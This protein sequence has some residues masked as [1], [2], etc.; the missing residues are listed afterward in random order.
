MTQRKS[1]L[2]P[3]RNFERGVCANN[4]TSGDLNSAGG[5]V[6]SPENTHTF[7]F[8][9]ATGA[10]LANVR[11]VLLDDVPW[12]YA[13][14]VCE[15]LGLKDTN[16]AL[17]GVD[18][19]DKGEHEYYSGSG[20]K[21]LLVNESGLYSL[22]FKSRKPA[23]REFKRWITSEV[24]PAIRVT[25]SYS[26][27]LPALGV[28]FSDP[29]AAARAWADEYEAKQQITG[30]AHRQAKYITHLESLFSEGLTPVQF[31]KRL[32]GVNTS[33]V[34][35]WLVVKN[36]LYDD[37]PNGHRATW[38]VLAYARDQYLTETSTTV[39]PKEKASFEAFRPVL[40]KK[41]AVWI[42]RRYL[43]G[44]L[45]MKADWNGELTHDKELA[46]L[47]NNS[48]TLST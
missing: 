10:L 38:R 28:D 11:A 32:N 21:P 37:T 35:A 7:V 30:Y 27:A 34:N 48:G 19:E 1:A 22:I 39:T 43:K 44:E 45:P 18:D 26:G 29:A 13:V 31:C 24:L 25:G 2:L 36:W 47:A 33:K 41:G 5:C 6:L 15:A 12:F 46:E 23:A 14:D 40:L 42:Y 16:K 3:G 8:R 4:T 9:P 20:R 17:L